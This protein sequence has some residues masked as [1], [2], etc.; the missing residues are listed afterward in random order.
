MDRS[1]TVAARIPAAVYRAARVS[2][3]LLICAAFAISVAAAQTAASVASQAEDL[4]K[5]GEFARAA[6]LL[7]PAAAAPARDPEI[8]IMLAVARLNLNQPQAAIEACERGLG[9]APR[10]PRLERYYA[11][12][13]VAKAPNDEIA[14]R[15]ERALKDDPASGVLQKALGTFLLRSRNPEGRA[16]DLLRNAVAQLP[17]DADAHFSYG[18]WACV[19][20]KQALCIEE[21]QK[22]LALADASNYDVKVQANTFIAITE[23]KRDRPEAARAAYERALQANRKL[24]PFSPDAAFLYVKFLLER[25]EDATARTLAEE[26]LTRAPSFAPARFERAKA[27][28]HDGSPEKAA[29]EGEASLESS[30]GEKPDLRAMHAFLVKVY[31]TL[32]RDADAA[33]HQAWVEANR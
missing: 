13:V 4:L 23:Q 28:F 22:A 9:A 5:R 33:R 15:L 3:R 8:Y 20:Q 26:I 31:T 29:E 17:R 12:L 18:Q 11:G 25:S 32:G 24:T 16:G 2:K 1:L 14:P 10:S 30:S 7:E 21:M 19:T 6:E 27:L